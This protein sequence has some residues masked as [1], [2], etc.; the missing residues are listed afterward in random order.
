MVSNRVSVEVPNA[1]RLCVDTLLAPADAPASSWMNA[2]KFE[3][4]GQ[5]CVSSSRSSNLSLLLQLILPTQK[6]QGC[7]F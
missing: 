7:P 1:E 6:E 3:P 2:A 5:L 4:S